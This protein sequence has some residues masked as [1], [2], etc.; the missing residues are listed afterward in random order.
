MA[1]PGSHDEWSLP[2]SLV[3]PVDRTDHPAP[4][5]EPMRILEE[6]EGLTGID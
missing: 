6:A 2:G 5:E 3:Q 4:A 1:R